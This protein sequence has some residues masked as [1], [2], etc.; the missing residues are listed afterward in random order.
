MNTTSAER[1]ANSNGIVEW[2]RAATTG[3]P[4]GGRG[5]IDGPLTLKNWPSKST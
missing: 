5:T 2:A 3:W 1:A 4:C